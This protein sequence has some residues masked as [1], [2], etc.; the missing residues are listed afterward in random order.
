VA[1]PTVENFNF[2][3]QRTGLAPGYAQRSQGRGRALRCIRLNFGRIH[4]FSITPLKN[5]S[6]AERANLLAKD[7]KEVAAGTYGEASNSTSSL[8]RQWT[9]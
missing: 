5:M 6:L 7:A 4:D 9:P 2:D 1:D 3:I 8:A